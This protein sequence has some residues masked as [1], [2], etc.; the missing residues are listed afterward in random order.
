MN[1][2]DSVPF[3]LKSP[4]AIQATPQGYK[5]Y[6]P[7]KL[8]QLQWGW[9]ASGRQ[10]LNRSRPLPRPLHVALEN[11]HLTFKKQ[12]ITAC[13][14]HRRKGDACV[15]PL[16]SNRTSSST[17]MFIAKLTQRLPGFSAIFRKP[18]CKTQ[19]FSCSLINSG[20]TWWYSWLGTAL[21]AGRSRVR[22]PMESFG[23]FIG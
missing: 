8:V 16:T 6:C 9:F 5:F 12:K 11:H 13:R 3:S 15:L 14:T 2:K 17:N 4:Y 18:H 10:T 22:F 1:N 19:I 23:F 21:R 7:R 20:G